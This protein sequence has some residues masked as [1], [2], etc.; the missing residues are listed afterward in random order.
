[1]EPYETFG[2]S[3]GDLWNGD[4]GRD[5]GKPAQSWQ[6]REQRESLRRKL[7]AFG[8]RHS[9][10]SIRPYDFGVCPETGYHDEGIQ[11]TCHDCGEV[12]D[13]EEYNRAIAED[14][15]CP[16]LYLKV[17]RSQTVEEAAM[18]MRTHKPQECPSCRGQAEKKAVVSEHQAA[19][20][21]PDEEVA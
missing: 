20:E 11:I 15:M 8:C 4:E 1:M 9:L 13:P 21:F 19:F 18:Y 10:A 5:A 14:P 17:S 6:V 2:A 7:N 16:A 3:D 12:F